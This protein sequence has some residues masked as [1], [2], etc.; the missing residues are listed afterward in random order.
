M[1]PFLAYLVRT[2]LHLQTV[3]MLHEN[4]LRLAKRLAPLQTSTR[5]PNL[6]LS[7]A[8]QICPAVCRRV[9]HRQGPC[10]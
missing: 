2:K 10:C 7:I 5:T 1:I 3:S 8:A 6:Y 4:F 9:N